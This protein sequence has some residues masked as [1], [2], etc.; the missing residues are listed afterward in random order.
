MPY[1]KTEVRSAHGC[2]IVTT[3]VL[4][5]ELA[6]ADSTTGTD[7]VVTLGFSGDREPLRT[8]AVMVYEVMG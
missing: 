6:H 3:T 7:A 2:A 4:S 8:Y 5:G 1:T